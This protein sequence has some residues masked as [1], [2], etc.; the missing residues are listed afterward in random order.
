MKKT[1]CKSPI[2][3]NSIF[4]LAFTFLSA[5]CDDRLPSTWSN[6]SAPKEGL[7]LKT[8]RVEI[9]PL[10]KTVMNP[11]GTVK[12]L[13]GDQVSVFDNKNGAVEKPVYV[14]NNTVTAEVEAS[15]TRYFSVYPYNKSSRIDVGTGE[16]YTV[17]NGVQAPSPEKFDRAAELSYAE[18]EAKDGLFSYKNMCAFVKFSIAD[19]EIE[20]LRFEGLSGEKIAGSVV[21][22]SDGGQA[23]IKSAKDGGLKSVK[24]FN[25]TDSPYF[26]KDKDYYFS[27]LPQTLEKGFKATLTKKGGAIGVYK[28]T[29]AK[30]FQKAHITDIGA[31]KCSEYRSDL[32]ADYVRTGKIEIAGTVYS[33]SEMPAYEVSNEKL[34]DVLNG[35]G[36][37]GIYFLD[38]EMDYDISSVNISGKVVLVGNDALK[39]VALK[40]KEDKSVMLS[41][42]E[43]I[44][45][46]VELDNS[47]RSGSIFVPD[48]DA[49]KTNFVRLAVDKSKFTNVHRSL[50]YYDLP[51][52]GIQ[53]IT[54]TNSKIEINIPEDKDIQLFNIWK[55]NPAS[56]KEFIFSN[57]I[58]YSKKMADVQILNALDNIK[59]PYASLEIKVNNNILYNI[60]SSKSMVKASSVNS[61]AFSGNLFYA[62]DKKPNDYF[63]L[64]GSQQASSI[65]GCGSSQD[66]KDAIKNFAYV[67]EG[68]GWT[69]YK[70]KAARVKYFLT[71]LSDANAESPF[72]E[73]DPISGEFKLKEQYSQYGPRN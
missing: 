33:I 51:D 10:T 26:L 57:N 48:K 7:T 70:K 36:K 61:L 64:Y 16:I 59:K 73:A 56:Y 38:P 31:L 8:F 21:L 27:I 41:S 28:H 71:H 24:V 62:S 53:K 29:G 52:L 18:T 37:D 32:H 40:F 47:G 6:Q 3:L 63:R 49:A 30:D 39:P 72:E 66:D 68:F 25:G 22:S 45:S 44:L 19:D 15:A 20:S 60:H 58:Y 46:N 4:I 12:W 1:L 69:N 67:L 43:L 2:H 17:L 50:V 54:F 5:S 14:F 11:D 55:S 13:S 34:S 35:S 9:E 23:S 42:G 65:T